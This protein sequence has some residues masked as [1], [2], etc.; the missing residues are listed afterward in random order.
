MPLSYADYLVQPPASEDGDSFRTLPEVFAA[1]RPGSVGEYAVRDTRRRW[2]WRQW[3]EESQALGA[4][5]EHLGIGAGDVVAVQLA[6]SWEFLLTH[7]AV[8]DL[9]AVM[10]PLHR[11]LGEREVRALLERAGARLLVVSADAAGAS[12][13]ARPGCVEHTLIAPGPASE[14]DSGGPGPAAPA[15][16]TELVRAHA[17]SRPAPVTVTPDTPFVLLPSSGTTSARPKICLH[18]HGGLLSNAAAVARDFRAGADRTLISASPFTHLFGLL[19]VHLSLLTGA[20]QALLPAWDVE[21]LRA[22][23]DPGERTALFAVP[24]QL[25]DLVQQAAAQD[26]GGEPMRLQE[27]RTGGAAVPGNLV[28]D[29]RR[30]LGAGIVVQWGMSELGAGMYTRP[31]DPPE[32]AVRGIGRPVTGSRARVAAPDGTPC[33]DGETGELQ[34][35]G[36]HLFRGYLHDPDTT[37]AAFTDD[38]WLR[39]GDRAARN[40]DG[41]FTY[42]GREAEVINVGGVKFSASEVEGLL[43]DLPF[44]ALAV[45]ARPDPRL[46]EVPCLVAALRPGTAIGLD[47]VRSHLRRKG[48]AEYK[49]PLELLVVDEV[50]V[51]PTGKV[52]RAALTA[53]LDAPGDGASPAWAASL[54]PLAPAERRR[55][56]RD[57]VE[58]ALREVTAT[59]GPEGAGADMAFRDRGVTSLAAVRLAGL[60][61]ARTG[62]PVATTAAFD[63]PSPAALAARLLVLA[64][65]ASETGTADGRSGEGGGGGRTVNP[66]TTP[67]D[68]VVITGIGCRFPGGVRTPDDLWQLVVDGRETA[69][70]FPGDRGWDLAALRHCDPDRPGTTPARGGSFLADAAGFDARFFGISPRE[71][72]AMDPQQRLLLETAWEALERAAIDP[73]SLRGS[74]A[75]VFVGMM[76]SDYAPRLTEAPEAFEGSLLT[77]NASSVASGRIAYTLGLTGPALPV[78]TACSSSL[79]AL[80]LARQSLL[81]GECDLAL[82]GGATVMSTAASFVDFGRQGALSADGRCK[83]FSEDADGAGWGEGAGVLVLE[84]LS[85]ARRAGHP[86]LAVLAGSAVNQDGASNGLTAPSG[87]A[88]QAVIRQ[89]LA[90]AQL[91]SAD[92]DL[93]EAHGTGTPLGDRIE[94]EALLAAYGPDRPEDRPLWIGSVKANI[95][96]TQA[97]AGVAGVIKTVLALHHGTFPRTLHADRP[98]PLVDGEKGSIRLLRRSLPWAR[99]ARPRRAAVSAFGI[100][101]TNG[102]LILQESPNPAGPPPRAA[103]P[104]REGRALPWVLSARTLPALR[105][106]AAGLAQAPAV[107]APEAARQLA[108]GRAVFEH[109]A[110]IVPAGPEELRRGLRAVAEGE[111]APQAVTGRARSHSRTVFVFP[112]QG[113]QWPGMA[114]GLLDASPAF[115]DAFAA[116]DRALA[117]HV[118][119]S[120]TDVL[121]GAP[122]APPLTRD[123]VAQTA[124][125]AVMVSLAEQ[126]RSYGVMPDAV[127]GHSQGEI[128]AAHVAGALGLADAAAAVARRAAAVL[129]LPAGAMATVALSR[130]DT[131]SRITGAAGQDADSLSVAAVNGPRSTVVSGAPAA[132]A[133]LVA[134]LTAEGV[135]ATAVPV[136]YA[137]HCASVEGLREPLVSA[138]AALAPRAARIPFY[139]TVDGALLDTTGL[140]GEYWYRNLRQPVEFDAAVRAALGDGF[141]GFLEMSPHPLL[142]HGVLETAESAG[143]PAAAVGTLRRGEG[144]LHRFLLSAAEAFVQ[145]VP[146]DW[147][148]SVPRP[149]PGTGAL[150]LPPYPFQRERHWLTPL[151]PAPGVRPGG[152][153]GLPDTLRPS[154]RPGAAAAPAPDGEG[155]V[156]GLV[157]SLTADVLG[158]RDGGG[159]AAEE[160]FLSAGMTSL[161]ATQLRARL[162]HRLGVAMAST[163]VFDHGTPAA[164]GRHLSRLLERRGAG[165]DGELP[166]GI[167]ALY[168]QALAT[169]RADVALR[170]IG[171]ASLLRPVFDAGSHAGHVPG[172]V[173]LADGDRTPALLCL[174]S[175]VPAGGPHEYAALARALPGRH[176]VH[177]LP[178]PGFR[179]GESVPADSRALLDVHTTALARLGPSSSYVLCGHSSGGLVARALAARLEQ[180]GRPAAGLV[181]LDTFQE[182]DLLRTDLMPYFLAAAAPR[183]SALA[184]AGVGTTRLTATGTYLR[185]L[186]GLPAGPV[187]TP[188]LLVRAALPLPGVPAGVPAPRPHDAHTV[189]VADGDHFTMMDAPRV[190]SVADAVGCWLAAL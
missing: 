85:E 104:W 171:D 180:L 120:V 190:A 116:C 94:A 14:P 11:A 119:W 43:G 137:S 38:G 9:G 62:L 69:G 88:Q 128:A 152:R 188:V 164:L 40:A 56:A 86:V 82:A 87:P 12:R 27:V 141:T 178:Q 140:T 102:H 52:A 54:A 19:S 23:A 96:H 83:P 42:R 18:S 106:A 21:A 176:S 92:V 76:S 129:P 13:A 121:R 113:A 55:R 89:A 151:S 160:T 177:A 163:A 68:P 165:T 61:A 33:A 142:T 95:G 34:F 79:V 73:E 183:E 3:S 47:E 17:G 44:A 20:R 131:A 66:R 67:D 98:I 25:R 4:G 50:P 112:G 158:Y 37:R 147:R 139:S 15:S 161:T 144:G 48:V 167:E 78:D 154:H 149:G 28:T 184:A 185:L 35:R 133:L 109:R 115:A 181:L 157:R 126:W 168:R 130:Q 189:A 125:F 100:S 150:D 122:G 70:E 30:L 187:A 24:A 29:I 91:S 8:A 111:W 7:V 117:A 39:T 2:T 1:A 170:L 153:A 84:R 135:R 90:D 31:E 36:P 53:L 64:G 124:L 182:D 77:G 6:N 75:G 173:R 22:L 41:T 99:S 51:T 60:I 105:A 45:G 175:V 114:T 118:N 63:H 148:E 97:A 172:A 156:L 143:L 93:A 81:R 65:E 32:A 57:L 107:T 132:I 179:P 103:A 127:I 162:S 74:R 155:A 136:G 5:L 110:V 59:A 49:W 169:G 145:G 72:A 46:G 16:F 108:A 26:G 58:D 134:G 71:A 80:H 186:T 138:L 146:V 101:G 174:P 166:D 10:L 159:P 123:D